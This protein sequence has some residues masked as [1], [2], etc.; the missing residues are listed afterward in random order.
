MTFPFEQ[1]FQ[2]PS[3][4]SC[5]PETSACGI[6]MEPGGK[7]S[8]QP[9]QTAKARSDY[10]VQSLHKGHGRHALHRI[11][12][13][14]AIPRTSFCPVVDRC[15]MRAK[16]LA[17]VRSSPSAGHRC[18]IVSGPSPNH[19]CNA[20]TP[21]KVLEFTS[22]GRVIQKTVTLFVRLSMHMSWCVSLVVLGA[23]FF[24][25]STPLSADSFISTKPP[26]CAAVL[27]A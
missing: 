24:S 26:S 23:V 11:S 3:R 4:I 22:P 13:T 14:I 8:F 27:N 17:V 7:G 19:S 9:G 6:S 5:P 1:R 15:E 10:R 12:T 20:G 18:T 2:E 25:H 21:R 16:R